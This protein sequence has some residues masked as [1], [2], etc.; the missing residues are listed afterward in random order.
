MKG[1]ILKDLTA[2]KSSM[3]TVVLIVLIFG[4][5]GAKS[6]SMYMS[7]FA[8]VYAAILP[9]TCMAYDERSRFNRY[10]MI[11]P[12]NQ[13]DIVLCK[14]VTG[15]ILAAA[16]T[17]VAVAMTAISGGSIGETVA[18]SI[19]IPALY[20][21]ILLPLMFKFGVEKSRIIVLVGVVIPAIGV[22]FMEEAG[23]LDNVVNAL[24]IA[25]EKTILLIGAAVLVVMYIVSILASLAVCK[26]KEW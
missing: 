14:Y 3:K 7:T 24:S 19:A 23:V 25:D 4:F 1:L 2:L 17:V 11:M 21:S 9:M 15:L 12:I 8:S 6:G 22:S 13:R 20:H 26:N 18:G 10:A 16:A 5:M